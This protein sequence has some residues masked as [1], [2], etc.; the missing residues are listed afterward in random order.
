MQADKHLELSFEIG[1]SLHRASQLT[2]DLF[3][4]ALD[5]VDITARQLTVLEII[6]QSK[7][8]S[9]MDICEIAGIDR[10]T[11]ADMIMRLIKKGYVVRERS[12]ADARRYELELTSDGHRILELARPIARKVEE[13]LLSAIPTDCIGPFRDGL[14]GVLTASR[15]A[16]S[17]VPRG[18]G[19]WSRG[20]C[21][22]QQVPEPEHELPWQLAP[23]RPGLQQKRGGRA[24]GRLM[25]AALSRNTIP[26]IVATALFMANLDATVLSTSLPPSRE[27]SAQPDSP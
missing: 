27:I 12:R 8:P 22:D 3:A 6:A 23:H 10:S 7:G 11:I 9:Q 21:Q 17:S 2:D 25:L 19:T 20:C 24:I 14:T 15:S 13:Q 18:S 4:A 16:H 5:G 1:H 26:L